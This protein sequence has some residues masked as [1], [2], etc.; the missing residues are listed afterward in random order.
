MAT[1]PDGFIHKVVAGSDKI[2]V[3]KTPAGKEEA[4]V[5]ELLQPYF[6][7][8]EAGDYFKITDVPADTVE[9]AMAGN[10]GYVPKGQSHLWP[11]R[12]A[13]AFSD[14]AFLEDRPEI[15]AWDEE[16]VLKKFMESGNKKLHPPAF[17]EDLK[18][19]RK[20]E[21]ST[22]PYPVLGSQTYKF[23][24]VAD[25][26]VYKVLLP[27][28]LPAEARIEIKK[29]DIEQTKKAL[30]AATIVVVFD[31][32]G[33]MAAF[34]TETARTIAGAVKSLDP[35]VVKKS[36]MGFVFYRDVGD[37][38]NLV[39]LSPLPI[40][41]A[42]K[43]LNEAAGLM[44]GGGDAAE[45]VLDAIYFA[46]HLYNWGQHGRRIL[47]G[48]LNDDAK[49]TTEGTLDPKGRIPAGLDVNAVA[50]G[51]FEANIPVI[52]VQ[53]GPNFGPN[54]ETVMQPLADN[55]GGKFI[56]W[57]SGATQKSIALAVTNKMSEAA[58]SSVAEGKETLSKMEFDYRGYAS[59]PLA[60]LD[61]EKLDR[62]R[63]NGVDFNID[64]GAGGVLVREGYMVENNDLL[65][66]KIQIEKET[67]QGLI[68]LYSVLGTTGVDSEAFLRSA[69]EA[70]AAI[71][72]EDYDKTETISELIRKNLGI[73][74]RSD[75][76]KFKLEY[77]DT[78]NREERLKY[79]KRIQDAGNILAKY[80]DA[81]LAEFDSNPAVWMPIA[82]LP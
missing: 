47:I 73:E 24:K 39:E 77:L 79:S 50:K 49:P 51:V 44:T 30:Q 32:T 76:L 41:D 8:C 38:E 33:S 82:A 46:T 27:A 69:G 54:L 40:E 53:A 67:L 48:V 14:I 13:L 75:L 17:Q 60:V 63:R 2:K 56:R 68:N 25:K 81:N 11:T 72:G 42:A 80:L 31:A 1:T 3:F 36:T 23:R 18:S 70:I 19:T 22:R 10:V 66:P 64:L 4:Y 6:V 57:D 55:T 61:G 34:A 62:L 71:A 7:I 45:P 35:D 12:E 37:A 20:R 16:A 43:A 65:E 15:V 26:R 58:T 78:L 28:A 52:T 59:I 29:G 9:E 5:M 21:R 74:F